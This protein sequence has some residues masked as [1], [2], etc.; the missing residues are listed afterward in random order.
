MTTTKSQMSDLMGLN[1][2]PSHLPHHMGRLTL[3]GHLT[4]SGL[5]PFFFPF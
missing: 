1:H 4:R 2:K 5:M 3:E